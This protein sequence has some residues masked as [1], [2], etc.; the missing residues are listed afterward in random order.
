[1]KK[2][3]IYYT[4]ILAT[5]CTSALTKTNPVALSVIPAPQEIQYLNGTFTLN[6]KTSLQIPTE[7]STLENLLNSNIQAVAHYKLTNR[8]S[9]KNSIQLK[10]DTTRISTP[11]GYRLHIS[12]K[13]VRITGKTE[14]GLFYGLQTL[15]QILNDERFYHPT[16]R[17]WQIPALEIQ[18]SPAFPYRGMHLDVSRHFFPKEYI[19]KWIDLMALYKI[20]TLH[21]HLTDAGG[22]R[23]EIKKYPELTR[24]AAWRTQIGWKEWWTAKDRQYL[25]EGT[26]GAY[27]GYYTQEDI[28]EIVAYAMNRHVE[29]IPEIEMP[30]HS[31]EIFA[32]YPHLCCSG[33]AY[34]NG[35]FCI[36]NEDTFEFIENVLTEIMELFPSRYIHIGGDE[37][38]K[39][40]WTKCPKCQKRKKEEKLKDERELQSYLIRRVGDFIEKQGREF[41]GWDEIL[42]GGLAPRAIVMSWRGEQGGIDAAR[43]QHQVIMTPG[44]YCYLDSYQDTPSTQPYTIGGFTPYLKT[45]SYNPIPE[46]L[47]PDEAR[48]ILG[49]QANLW[50]EYI[51]TP[52]HVEYM[53]FPR[54]LSLSEVVWTPQEKKNPEDFKRRIEQHV[55]WLRANGV[56]AFPLSDRIDFITEV[57]TMRK[58]I[59]V[60]FDSEKY[61]PEIRYT[62]DGTLPDITSPRYEKPLYIRDSAIVS[63]AIFENG[64][65][66]ETV[67]SQRIDYHKAIGKKVTYNKL[68]SGAYPAAGKGTL[69][70]GLRGGLTYSDGRWQGFLNHVDILIDLG[71]VQ[72]ISYVSTTFMQLTG[73]GVYIPDYVRVKISED[74]KTYKEIATI[75][76]DVPT[77][78]PDLRFKEF[79]FRFHEKA[80]YVHLFAKKHAGFQFIDEV[81]VH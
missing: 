22:W 80:R 48:Y 20:N 18:D 21:W 1:M 6:E 43:S 17:S 57:D 45:Y 37:A 62:L 14:T 13:G 9:D 19:L 74:G 64:K 25:E 79:T 65:R 36:G 50:T 72:D 46:S 26:P 47:S 38:S 70:D 7:W 16:T 77:D 78:I 30:G 39:A 34:R 31:E 73:P 3:F 75:Q 35:E 4:I 5:A 11:E 59:K 42:E 44:A 41:I 51:S 32:V 76:N 24:T 2:W 60:S 29:I 56:N 67:I 10:I 40:A 68:Y 55:K 61:N 66:S 58:A 69:T 53:L 27:G 52:E 49:A 63:S 81:V 28:R 54:L 12:P 23:V 8:N 71:E 33:K 15:R